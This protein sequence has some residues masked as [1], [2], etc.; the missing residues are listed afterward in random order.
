VGAAAPLLP[1]PAARTFYNVADALLPPE[2]GRPG[3]GDVDLLAVIERSETLRAHA[4]WR[5]VRRALRWIEWGPRLA[6]RA[7][8]GFSWLPRERR[9]ALLERWSGSRLEVRRR[10]LGEL[11]RLVQGAWEAA[12]RES[13][14][15]R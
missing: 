7:P 14:R 13:P 15:E 10:D 5:R 1:P 9:R 12:Q 3:G 4:D 6:L 11:V 8:R 2:P